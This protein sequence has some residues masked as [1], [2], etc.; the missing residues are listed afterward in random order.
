MPILSLLAKLGLDKTGFDTGLDA[1]GKKVTAF[2]GNLKSTLGSAFGAAAVTAAITQ[3]TRSS[4][5]FAAN[6]VDVSEKLNI[7]TREAQNYSLA[8]KLAGSDVQFLANK[9][10]ALR[11]NLRRAKEAGE[12]PFAKFGFEARSAQEAIENLSAHIDKFGGFDE[13]QWEAL[14]KVTGGPRGA[15]K[16]AQILRDISQARRR[17]LLMGPEEVERLDQAR[18]TISVIGNNLTVLWGTF[19]SKVANART[20]ARSAGGA[21]GGSLFGTAISSLFSSKEVGG[22]KNY[23]VDESAIEM[24][25]ASEEAARVAHMRDQD[26][27]LKLEK[28]TFELNERTRVSKLT[29]A[30][31][32][33]ELLRERLTLEKNLIDT[34]EDDV[35]THMMRRRLAQ[36]NAELAGLEAKNLNAIGK[37]STFSES[38]FGRI[39]AFTGAAASAALPPG[40]REQLAALTQIQQTL[41]M[42]G[43]VIKDVKR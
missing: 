11:D 19:L 18:D 21:F 12:N 14:S 38:A 20:A 42:K 33:N 17:G 30:E 43:I 7:T 9:F 36:V 1:A 24:R 13:G 35:G 40:A 41:A 27:L 26:E 5:D 37:R 25:L 4:I 8:A 2:A 28:E 22:H 39:G 32:L 10:E 6:T 31:R 3:L 16:M 23:G 34:Q 15:G 29:T